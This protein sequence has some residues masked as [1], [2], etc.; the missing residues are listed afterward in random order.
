MPHC[1]E[2]DSSHGSP[3]APHPEVAA[4]RPPRRLVRFAPD[5]VDE[6]P[7]ARPLR[8]DV[9]GCLAG[10]VLA[11]RDA[12]RELG[13]GWSFMYG[14]FGLNDD[15]D[16]VSVSG[17]RISVMV[18]SGQDIDRRRLEAAGWAE[19]QPLPAPRSPR[20]EPLRIG[21]TALLELIDAT[22]HAFRGDGATDGYIHAAV[23]SDRY[24][25]CIA[26]DLTT[27]IAAAKVLGWVILHGREQETTVMAVCGVVDRRLIETVARLGISLVVT[28]AIAT[29]DALRAA[30]GLSLSIV[31]L[32]LSRTPGLFVDSGHIEL[33]PAED[34]PESTDDK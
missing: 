12:P 33:L 4:V 34:G 7:V 14:F 28:S 26:R 19:P 27:D 3:G 1:S 24:V 2:P 25:H 18:A 23:T 9:N 10:T 30:N 5:I 8:I 22:W 13:A 32:A 15:L 6:L 20:G 31:G 16:R 17:D 21:E 11:I 29:A